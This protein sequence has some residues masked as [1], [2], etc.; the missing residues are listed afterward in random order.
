MIGGSSARGVNR[1]ALLQ[2]A[3]ITALLAAC[4]GGK[5]P[6]VESA[7]TSPAP[8]VGT[9]TPATSATSAAGSAS[10]TTVA[11]APVPTATTTA[12]AGPGGHLVYRDRTRVGVHDVAAGTEVLFTPPPSPLVEPGVAVSRDGRASLVL[13][14]ERDGSF[15]LATFGLD[16][17]RLGSFTLG[18]PGATVTGAARLAADGGRFLLGVDEPVSPT[19]AQRMSRA[20]LVDV[21]SGAVVAVADGFD[22]PVWAGDDVLVRNP[23]TGVVHLLNGQLRSKGILSKVI[24]SARPGAFDVSA[25]GRFVVH[26]IV[27]ANQLWAYDRET[28]EHW[29]AAV[30]ETAELLS[31]TLSPDNA[32]LAF[33]ARGPQGHV[34]H[35]VPFVALRTVAVRAEQH[36]LTTGLAD[37]TGRIGWTV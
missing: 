17:G 37:C 14:G 4:R 24:T 5:S 19:V 26:E 33:L 35:V 15:V 25:D 22:A 27:G 9:A 7:S 32:R 11:T 2:G 29:T 28:G 36:A 34:P 13:A 8:T 10:P 6:S 12:A 23:A 31:P 30:H 16:G 3:A 21:R 1:R 18:R 20:L